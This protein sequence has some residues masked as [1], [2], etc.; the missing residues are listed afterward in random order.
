MTHDSAG[1]N[2]C[3]LMLQVDSTAA[4]RLLDKGP[5]GQ[6]AAACKAF[7]EFWGEKAELRRFPVRYTL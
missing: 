1:L 5:P 7:R 4:L 6:D 3:C 2:L